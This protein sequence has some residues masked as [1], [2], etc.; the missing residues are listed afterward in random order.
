VHGLASIEQ[1]VLLTV[2]SKICTNWKSPDCIRDLAEN[3]AIMICPLLVTCR[4]V[5]DNG[6]A[7]LLRTDAE[8]VMSSTRLPQS[9][10]HLRVSY[11]RVVPANR[12][13]DPP[14]ILV[15]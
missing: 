7:L 3:F 9:L 15:S 8:L 2:E 14:V 4:D 6:Y 13:L 11:S 10:R 12:P 5:L 1:Q